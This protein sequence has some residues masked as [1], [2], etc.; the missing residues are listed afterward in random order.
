MSFIADLFSNVDTKIPMIAICICI[1]LFVICVPIGLI[2][3]YSFRNQY[4][5]DWLEDPI[6]DYSYF[7]T[8]L[9]KCCTK[10]AYRMM[11]SCN[12]SDYE[13]FYNKMREKI[14]P[15]FFR[16]V[17]TE[18]H[19]D[20]W[21]FS[22]QFK[23]FVLNNWSESKVRDFYSVACMFMDYMWQDFSHV[24]YVS[25]DYI[26]GLTRDV[27]NKVMQTEAARELQR[28]I[29][30]EVAT[31]NEIDTKEKDE[32]TKKLIVASYNCA[33]R[34]LKLHNNRGLNPVNTDRLTDDFVEKL[35]SYRVYTQP[36]LLSMASDDEAVDLHCPG[37]YI[38]YNTF[39]GKYFVGKSDSIFVRVYTLIS[40][41]YCEECL[42]LK[43]DIESGHLILV[44]FVKLEDSGYDDLSKL[45]RD[46]ILSYDCRQDK[47]YN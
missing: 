13:L 6:P 1:G 20:K 42:A 8:K 44:K 34:D 47:G 7:M 35:L 24:Q 25:H 19:W 46:L 5:V 41:S 26:E 29:L 10:Y 3:R 21:Y 37:C 16:P 23:S 40:S 27:V 39:T 17:T 22:S 30:N 45:Q 38:I 18:D 31:Q 9:E 36:K 15:L 32:L 43:K 12:G 11:Y 2:I 4:L 28:Q 14:Q 33:I